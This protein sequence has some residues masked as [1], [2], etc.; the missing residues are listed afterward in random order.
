VI[1]S[2]LES[3]ALLVEELPGDVTPTR[4]AFGP[5]W[6]ALSSTALTTLPQPAVRVDAVLGD[7]VELAGYSVA[8]APTGAPVIQAE[9]AVDVT[10]F[11]QIEADWPPGVGISLRPTQN[12]AFIPDPAT[13]GVIQRDASAPVQGLTLPIQPGEQIADAYRIPMPNGADGVMLIVYRTMET[14]FENLLELPLQLE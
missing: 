9:S 6:L 5:D 8:S 11:W 7:G 3:T 10:L 2:T 14:G 4:T 13:G 12:G 1:L